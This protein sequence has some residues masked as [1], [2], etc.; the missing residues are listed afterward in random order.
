M[1]CT[2]RYRSFFIGG[3]MR[4]IDL[5]SFLSNYY[6]IVNNN[7]KIN[8]LTHSDIKILFPYIKRSSFR[9]LKKDSMSIY[10]GDMVMVYDCKGNILPY[11]N[12]HLDIHEYVI[13][14]ANYALKEVI[15]INDGCLNQMSK[16][17]LLKLRSF[18]R[19]KHQFSDEKVV[20]DVIRNKK[21]Y[22]VIKYKRKKMMLRM[23]DFYDKD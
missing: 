3:F 23:E 9:D 13:P 17:Q 6:G 1:L 2:P 22:Q 16:K 14:N 4:S 12:P 10:K 5:I 18:L 15:N 20:V 19:K 8:Q 7:L 11:I 21:D